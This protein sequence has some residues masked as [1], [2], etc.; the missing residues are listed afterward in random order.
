MKEKMIPTMK[1]PIHNVNN[2]IKRRYSISLGINCFIP[3][4]ITEETKIGIN[5]GD[6]TRNLPIVY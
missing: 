4:I 2:D 6:N 1:N 3:I 5:S